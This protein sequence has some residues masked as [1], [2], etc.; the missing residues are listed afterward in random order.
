MIRPHLEYASPVWNPH[1]ASDTQKLESVQRFATKVCSKNWTMNYNERLTFLDI[2]TLEK[3]RKIFDLCFLHNIIN[4]RANF[5]DAPIS[6]R[7]VDLHYPTRN[8]NSLTL[9]TLNGHTVQH[10]ESYFPR[11]IRLW[12]SLPYSV[13]G[14]E[15]TKNFK[16]ELLQYL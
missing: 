10:S 7:N 12:N 15:S 3:R 13:A 6:Y 4:G 2:P 8:V 14:T 9:N 5:P 11:T 1:T 16:N